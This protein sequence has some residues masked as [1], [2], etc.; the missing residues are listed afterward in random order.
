MFVKVTIII[1]IFISHVDVLLALLIFT[2]LIQLLDPHDLHTSF[3]DVLNFEDL[4]LLLD[5]YMEIS[6]IFHAN[7]LHE[8]CMIIK[9]NSEEDCL[10]VE[11][12]GIVLDRLIMFLP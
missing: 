5:A 11:L 2:W 7:V 3:V 6:N 8:N 10:L 12:S 9:K 1:I 4:Q